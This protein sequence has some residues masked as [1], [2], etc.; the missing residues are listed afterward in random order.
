[1]KPFCKYMAIFKT[2]KQKMKIKTKIIQI[3]PKNVQ[4]MAEAF[5]CSKTF[6][7]NALAYRSNSELAFKVRD[8][9]VKFYGGEETFKF[10]VR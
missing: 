8:D 5:N 3:P 7:W 2:N 6:I 9:A 1:M 10:I 4:K